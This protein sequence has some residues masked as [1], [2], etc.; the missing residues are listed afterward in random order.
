MVEG[1]LTAR[2]REARARPLAD[3]ERELDA[4]VVRVNVTWK[5]APSAAKRTAKAAVA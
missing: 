3:A 4:I 1:D 2:R 5:H